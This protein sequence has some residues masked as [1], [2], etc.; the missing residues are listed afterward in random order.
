MLTNILFLTQEDVFVVLKIS[1]IS[2]SAF[3]L[4]IPQISYLYN[5]Y[6]RQDGG[7][8]RLAYNVL[9]VNDVLDFAE[10][11]VSRAGKIQ[12]VAQPVAPKARS[13]YLLLYA[14][15]IIYFTARML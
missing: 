6:S 11:R 3:P 15:R 1:K 14:G 7:F 4:F 13:V 8:P 10:K 12:N 5:I 2:L 9:Q